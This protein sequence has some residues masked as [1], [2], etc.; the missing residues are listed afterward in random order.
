[1]TPATANPPRN[2]IRRTA[3]PLLIL[4]AAAVPLWL[5]HARIQTS[6]HPL[7][8]QLRAVSWLRVALGIAVIYLCFVLR[9]ARWSVLLSPMRKTSLWQ[10]LPIQFIGFAGV[11]ILGRV[12]DLSRPYMTARRTETA[13]TTQIAIYSLERTFDLAAAAILFSATLAFAPASM[14]HHHTFARAGVLS[15]AATMLLA[16]VAISI[17]I[18]GKRVAQLTERLLQPV[19]QKLATVI[20]ARILDLQQGFG[21]ITTFGEFVAAMSLSLL[22]WMGIASCYLLGATAFRASP[23]LAGFSLSA[24]M[25]VLATG[26]GGGIIQLPI[27]GWFTQVALFATT[28]HTLFAVPVE[29]ATACA[30]VIFCITNLSVIPAGLLTA[31]IQ[32]INLRELHSL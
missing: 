7:R 8:E 25:L 32:G 4:L 31:Y 19:S 27:L 17:R 15:L 20:A 26:I 28:M 18:A 2:N 9:A 11:A 21:A 29:T 16:A 5:F 24:T 23:Q 13:V 30:A 22:M 1:M 12:A 10:L 6:W 14:P 3:I